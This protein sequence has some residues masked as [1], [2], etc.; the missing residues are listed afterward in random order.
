MSRVRTYVYTLTVMLKR[1][2]T[3]TTRYDDVIRQYIPPQAI[4]EYQAFKDACEGFLA[5]LA[6][7]VK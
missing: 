7:P 2:A 5:A 4:E 6:V 1:V 3:Y